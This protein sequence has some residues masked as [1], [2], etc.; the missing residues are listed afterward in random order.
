MKHEAAGK[1]CAW[2]SPRPVP[3]PDELVEDVITIPRPLFI[4]LHFIGE[5]GSSTVVHHGP[6]FPEDIA[7][8]NVLSLN[9]LLDQSTF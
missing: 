8:V 2:L 9:M 1:F 7:P 5:S 3:R 4:P 6:I